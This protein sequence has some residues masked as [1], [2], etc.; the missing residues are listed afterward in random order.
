VTAYL[1]YR[2]AI[3]TAQRSPASTGLLTA[4]ANATADPQQETDGKM[5]LQYRINHLAWRGTPGRPRVT[6]TESRAHANPYPTVTVRDCPT[7]S[8]SWK[9]Y[10][11]TT[12]KPVPVTYPKGSAKRPFAVTAT[13][14]DY[15]SHWLVEKVT[16]YM[17]KTCEP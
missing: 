8:A 9:P 6:V 3:N 10:D 12:N 15:Q 1:K 13:V 11:T 5:L 16:T 14:V 4:V 17:R 2:E 7:V